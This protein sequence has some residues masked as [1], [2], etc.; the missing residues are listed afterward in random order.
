MEK[1]T[2]SNKVL[3]TAVR[4]D[5][6]QSEPPGSEVLGNTSD[7]GVSKLPQLD[8]LAFRVLRN[9]KKYPIVT[10][11]DPDRPRTTALKC[12]GEVDFSIE[13]STK[14]ELDDV[15][16]D[17]CPLIDSIRPCRVVL[18]DC[19]SLTRSEKPVKLLIS[20]PEK[21]HSANS[22]QSDDLQYLDSLD[23]KTPIVWPNPYQN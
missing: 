3:G 5:A 10:D 23:Q 2:Y 21:T 6:K 11:P 18:D 9:G 16:L 1:L 12:E 4:L 8:N 14:T 22:Q 20:S 13:S 7:A 17:S 15:P 19:W